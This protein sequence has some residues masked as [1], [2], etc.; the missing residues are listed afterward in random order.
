MF[1][2]VTNMYFGTLQ[3]MHILSVSVSRDNL[4]DRAK[5]RQVLNLVAKAYGKI[6]KSRLS[7]IHRMMK[8]S[9]S[10]A[11]RPYLKIMKKSEV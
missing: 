11:V 10:N 5:L 3:K 7:E 9:P 4:K 1:S 2:D 6:V 8:A